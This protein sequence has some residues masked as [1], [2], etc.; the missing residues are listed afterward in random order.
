MALARCYEHEWPTGRTVAYVAR[1]QPVGHPESSTI[2]GIPE[3]RNPAQV[4]LTREEANA[5]AEGE[6]IVGF[7]TNTVRARVRPKTMER[8]R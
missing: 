1:V 7:R 6:E 2:C 4:Y 8:R 5:V 3:C